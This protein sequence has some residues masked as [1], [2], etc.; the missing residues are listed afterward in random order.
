MVHFGSQE[1]SQVQIML[2]GSGG[3]YITRNW[4][5]VNAEVHNDACRGTLTAHGVDRNAAG[6]TFA[7]TPY[8]PI[9]EQK[10][11]LRSASRLAQA[12]PAWSIL[13]RR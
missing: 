8:P 2:H 6:S 9:W 3:L 1:R 5:F 12:S 13:R 10:I 11:A 4:M 7:L